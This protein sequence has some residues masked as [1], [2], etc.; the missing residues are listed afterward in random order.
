MGRRE[1]KRSSCHKEED[2]QTE[3]DTETESQLKFGTIV[4]CEEFSILA[5]NW[6]WNL[7][8]NETRT[9][10]DINIRL[11]RFSLE[12]ETNSVHEKWCSRS[13]MWTSRKRWKWNETSNVLNGTG[14]LREFGASGKINS[15]DK[16]G[17]EKFRLISRD[18]GGRTDRSLLQYLAFKQ[19]RVYPPQWCALSRRTV[20]MCRI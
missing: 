5:P 6:N 11:K 13:K 2:L 18:T 1:T 16:H 15:V 8:Q 14:S 7:T 10:N 3:R 12:L 4:S 17:V 20:R 9:V 19:F